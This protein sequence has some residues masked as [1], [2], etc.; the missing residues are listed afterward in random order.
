MPLITTAITLGAATTNYAV[1][2]FTGTSAVGV[3]AAVGGY[4]WGKSNKDGDYKK[5][6]L[7]LEKE[8]N[9]RIGKVTGVAQNLEAYAHSIESTISSNTTSTQLSIDKTSTAC[10][11]ASTQLEPTIE[12]FSKTLE[13]VDGL[14]E[15]V[16]D[17]LMPVV[18]LL[19]EKI[20]GLEKTHVSLQE[21]ASDLN[22]TVLELNREVEKHQLLTAQL[23]E[24]N[25][26][27]NKTMTEKQDALC[28]TKAKLEELKNHYD[29]RLK[30]LEEKLAYSN[31][32]LF[33]KKGEI[34][35]LLDG[36]REL[37]HMIKNIQGEQDV[38]STTPSDGPSTHSVRMFGY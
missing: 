13:L 1:W 2:Y 11:K 38:D 35:T 27:D 30:N 6:L 16:P 36:N 37:I 33:E 18:R 3:A 34:N 29:F 7:N 20:S 14:C 15:Q 5:N 22:K 26:S 21:T 17:E 9:D 12:A 28:Q 19:K 24:T 23:K 31:A 25:K 10:D 4:F 8:K 32:E